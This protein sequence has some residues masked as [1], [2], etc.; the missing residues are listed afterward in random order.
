MPRLSKVNRDPKTKFL[1]KSTITKSV[2][3]V[4]LKAA[5]GKKL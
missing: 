2:V 5:D 3:T 1:N 4:N